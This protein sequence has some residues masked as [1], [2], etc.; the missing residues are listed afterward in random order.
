[1]PKLLSL[2]IEGFRS[3]RDELTVNFPE[4]QPVILIGEN[5]AGKSN[6][7]RA[8]DLLFGDYSPKYRKFESYDHYDRDPNNAILIQAEISG[9]RNRLGQY[10]EYNC[11]GFK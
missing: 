5:N 9:I 2:T 3:I 1:M 4:N 10:G 11:K 6:I 7:V 8:I